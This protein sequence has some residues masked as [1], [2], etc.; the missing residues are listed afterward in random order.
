MLFLL[1]L[2]V[3]C[4]YLISLVLRIEI[5]LFKVLLILVIAVFFILVLLSGVSAA[6]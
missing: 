4:G 2:L 6:A 3:I 5:M 1:I